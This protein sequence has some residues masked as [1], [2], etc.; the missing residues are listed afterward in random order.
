MS[1]EDYQRAEDVVYPFS[2]RNYIGEYNPSH[3]TD[4]DVNKLIQDVFENGFDTVKMSIAEF[5]DTMVLAI[6]DDYVDDNKPVYQ[7]YVCKNVDT[8]ACTKD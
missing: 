5:G 6:E 4:A 8:T 2:F 7:L 3:C 1:P